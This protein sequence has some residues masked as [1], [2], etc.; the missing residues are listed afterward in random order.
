MKFECRKCGKLV[1]F[2]DAICYQ[3]RNGFGNTVDWEMYDAECYEKVKAEHEA[4]AEE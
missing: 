1:D 3:A 4:E 2:Q